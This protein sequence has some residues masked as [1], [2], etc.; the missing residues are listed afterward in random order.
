MGFFLIKL[1]H[2]LAFIPHEMDEPGR[3]SHLTIRMALTEVL[4]QPPMQV[5]RQ[6]VVLQSVGGVEIK[7]GQSWP[8]IYSCEWQRRLMLPFW[9]QKRLFLFV[10][11]WKAG[12][13]PF[14]RYILVDPT[15]KALWSQSNYADNYLEITNMN[16]KTFAAAIGTII[17]IMYV[18]PFKPCLETCIPC[19]LDIIQLYSGGT[20]NEI[21]SWG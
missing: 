8:V 14:K 6:P 1:F 12:N 11:V 7:H 3:F 2:L 17:S 20:Y 15:D 19:I 13:D 21:R 5:G 10:S 18:F 4:V 16:N 9:T